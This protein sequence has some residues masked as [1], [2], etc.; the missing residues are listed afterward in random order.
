MREAV[1]RFLNAASSGTYKECLSQLEQSMIG[2]PSSKDTPP[3]PDPPQQ[4]IALASIASQ[5]GDASLAI[6]KRLAP[7]GLQVALSVAAYSAS[8]GFFQVS[9]GRSTHAHS[10]R[11]AALHLHKTPLQHRERGTWQ[12]AHTFTHTTSSH[13]PAGCGLRSS[14]LLHHTHHRPS[15]GLPGCGRL[16]GSV[17]ARRKTS[18]QAGEHRC[19]DQSRTTEAQV[20]PQGFLCTQAPLCHPLPAGRRRRLSQAHR[21]TLVGRL[22]GR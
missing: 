15:S 3:P 4:H 17:S 13:P 22:Q 14:S 10:S 21:D 20:S 18:R 1:L 11:G 7:F 8:L 16:V 9:P 6:V 5:A 2:L 19:R 12:R